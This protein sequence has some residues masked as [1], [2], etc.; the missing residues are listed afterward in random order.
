MFENKGCTNFEIQEAAVTN[1]RTVAAIYIW[2][3]STDFASRQPTGAWNFLGSFQSF[4]RFCLP[5]F[6]N[7]EE[8]GRNPCGVTILVHELLRHTLLNLGGKNLTCISWNQRSR[9]QFY[10]LQTKMSHF[11]FCHFI[12]TDHVRFLSLYTGYPRRKGPNFGRVF[13]RSNYTDIT[14][15][16]YIQRSMVTEILNIEK[17]G[18][19]WC[20]RTVLCPW[21]HTRLIRLTCK[22]TFLRY[23]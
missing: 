3:F 13:L 9:K 20:L 12:G 21:R 17:W 11:Q 8:V 10:V 16:T 15:N 22:A 14:Q 2:V 4:W 19:V 23:R 6:E 5:L 18:L 1:F 7:L